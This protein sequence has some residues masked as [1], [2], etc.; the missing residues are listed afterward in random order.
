MRYAVCGMR[1]AV[2]GMR[3]AVCGMRYA[4]CGMRYAGSIAHN[5]S[6]CTTAAAQTSSLSSNYS[7]LNS[8]CNYFINSNSP[9]DNLTAESF[10]HDKILPSLVSLQA[11][12][13]ALA[14]LF[15]AAVV[16]KSVTKGGG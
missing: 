13:I 15:F 3:Y 5:H 6:S 11:R 12:L 2:C 16:V 9:L 7:H 4:V 10:T 1:Y 8:H 14:F